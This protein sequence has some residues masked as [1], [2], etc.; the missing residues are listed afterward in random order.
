MPVCQAAGRVVLFGRVRLPGAP[1]GAVSERVVCVA[2]GEGGIVTQDVRAAGAAAAVAKR[3]LLCCAAVQPQ[4]AA[5]G[6]R[7]G[8]CKCST[9]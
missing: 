7:C 1:F 3:Q 6:E 2:T 9:V 4:W 5:M 8:S